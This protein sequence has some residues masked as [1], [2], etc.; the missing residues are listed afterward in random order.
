MPG[1]KV[2]ISLSLT[3]LSLLAFRSGSAVK[4][5]AHIFIHLLKAQRTT[6]VPFPCHGLSVFFI[7][8]NWDTINFSW[9]IQTVK[10]GGRESSV[11][12][13]RNV[14]NCQAAII[15]HHHWLLATTLAFALWSKRLWWSLMQ[16]WKWCWQ[17]SFYRKDSKRCQ[18]LLCMFWYTWKHTLMAAHVIPAPADSHSIWSKSSLC[19][20]MCNIC[21]I[22]SHT[23]TCPACHSNQVPV[24]W[25]PWQHSTLNGRPSVAELKKYF[26]LKVHYATFLRAYTQTKTQSSWYNSSL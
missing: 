8:D 14:A 7:A 21:H 5:I 15:N 25:L 3:L 19:V 26:V 6:W 13:E 17:W 24:G 11:E 18:G 1:G 10:T 12:K 4:P 22:P 16:W 9:S 23:T 2:V 20:P